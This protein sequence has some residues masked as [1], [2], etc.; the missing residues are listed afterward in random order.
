[1]K[2]SLNIAVK[3]LTVAPSPLLDR[4]IGMLIETH[5][6]AAARRSDGLL[7]HA[8]LIKSL[9]AAVVLVAGLLCTM[10]LYKK[11]S[12]A[13]YSLRQTV[14]ALGAVRS[15]QMAVVNDPA[16]SRITMLINPET[17][18]ADYVRRQSQETGDVTIT[19]PGQTYAYVKAKNEVTLAS[20]DVSGSSLNFRD[21][22]NSLIYQT[23]AKGPRI[24]IFK[25]YNDLAGTDVV[26]VSIVRKNK[27]LAGRLLIDP[28]TK[29]PIFIAIDSNGQLIYYGPVEYDVKIDNKD[30]EFVIPE[31]ASVIDTRPE[32]LKNAQRMET[33]TLDGQKKTTP[34]GRFGR[35]SFPD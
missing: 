13:A 9:A 22:V 20:K 19:I 28:E 1:M 21:F 10:T 25:G 27:T 15:V 7:S 24:V 6:R 14:K 29:L 35:V 3:E 8:L 12:P 16:R 11:S 26:T 31:G 5:P 34:Y 30:F 17:G 23:R 18:R 32:E 2:E 4:R 33:Q